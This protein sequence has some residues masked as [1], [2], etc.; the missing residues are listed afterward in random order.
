[1]VAR[2]LI[3]V[4]GR[5]GD[6][7]RVYGSSGIWSELLSRAEGYLGSEVIAQSRA[8]RRYLA[9]DYWTSHFDFESFRAQYRRECERF[10]ELVAFEG[11][12]EKE[13]FLG[14]YYK[15]DPDEGADIVPA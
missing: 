7:E 8:Q 2:E 13:N 1:V 4:D 14:S 9:S 10:A 5:E 12:L 15:P 11:L 6:V 3:A